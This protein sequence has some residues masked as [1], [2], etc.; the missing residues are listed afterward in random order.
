MSLQKTVWFFSKT[1]I[2]MTVYVIIEFAELIS[3]FSFLVHP[4]ADACL[5]ANKQSI[6]IVANFN[7]TLLP[8]ED[9][10]RL[11]IQIYKNS[12]V[13][14]VHISPACSVPTN[15]FFSPGAELLI[16]LMVRVL[17]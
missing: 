8:A 2:R 17:L 10:L 6:S 13:L 5:A 12:E 1:L 16:T 4:D 15:M 11:S 7:F 9:V 14:T 3:S